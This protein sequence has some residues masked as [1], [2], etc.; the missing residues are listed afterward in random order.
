[1]LATGWNFAVLK[2]HIRYFKNN[3]I[4]T[5]TRH[6]FIDR[7]EVQEDIKTL[8]EAEIKFWEHVQHKT[9]PALI[10]PEI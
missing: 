3:D 4:C 5:A 1:M 7:N 9:K 8:L 2:A 10:L 6:Y